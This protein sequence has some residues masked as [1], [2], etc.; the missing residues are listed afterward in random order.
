MIRSLAG[1]VVCSRGHD[2]TVFSLDPRIGMTAGRL[3]GRM[4]S[5]A[6]GT[7]T[8]R[9]ATRDRAVIGYRSAE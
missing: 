5:Q 6:Q 9:P 7:A 3:P 2:R 4:R 8:C 1:R